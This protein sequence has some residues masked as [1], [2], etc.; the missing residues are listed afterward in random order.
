[1]IKF[2]SNHRLH[3]FSRFLLEN[4]GMD[5]ALGVATWMS[6]KNTGYEKIIIM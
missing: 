3:N 4:C 1:M 5:A 6:R 2:D